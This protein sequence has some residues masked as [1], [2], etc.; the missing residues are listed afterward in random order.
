MNQMLRKARV[1]LVTYYAHMLEYR[2][3]LFFWTL[4]GSMSL[5]M[6]GIWMEAAGS[7]RF[8]LAPVDFARYFIA[9]FT[10]R[11]LMLV[12]V[13]WEFEEQVVQGK[14]SPQLL[15]P[16][17]PVWR[18]VAMHLSE[19][20]ARAPFLLVV[21]GLFFA[22]YPQ[23]FWLPTLEN[24]LLFVLVIVLAFIVRF[25]IQYTAALLAFWTERA[26]A[27][28]QLWFLL[29]LFLSGYIA[30]L[31]VFPPVVREIA[32]WTPFPY[33][34]HFPAA[35]LVGLP[36]NVPR[37]LMTM[38]GWGMI[39]YALNRWLWRRGVKHYSGMGA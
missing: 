2:A 4:S 1:L 18:H 17:D 7:G 6:M 5:I 26:S 3:E 39:F 32:L 35:I 20:V 38:L 12:W 23:G 28:E 13:I 25:S 15:Q 31:E 11:Q 36:V 24:L 8:G 27:I 29:Y 34:L 9:A 30:P 19:R 16:I 22:L 37:G 14:L 21:L 10:V 33:F